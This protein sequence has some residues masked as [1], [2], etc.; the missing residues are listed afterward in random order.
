MTT[1]YRILIQDAFRSLFFFLPVLSSLILS[2]M[3]SSPAKI[4]LSFSFWLTWT[5]RRCFLLYS[6]ATSYPMSILNACTYLWMTYQINILV[7]R[8]MG[9]ELNFRFLGKQQFCLETRMKT[10]VTWVVHQFSISGTSVDHQ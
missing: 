9:M 8:K 5:W 2:L 4:L 1:L 3:E 7:S 10:D 6:S